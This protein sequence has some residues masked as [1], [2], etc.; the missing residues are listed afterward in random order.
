MKD[1]TL[2]LFLDQ[3]GEP[4][5]LHD[6]E[7]M[8]VDQ[9]RKVLKNWELFLKSGM[10]KEHFT[11]ALYHHLINHCSF[12]AHYDRAGFY[13]T[14]F[15]SGDMA[16]HFLSQFDTRGGRIPRS[17]EYGETYWIA[18]GNDVCQSYYDINIEM[19]RI[20]WKYIPILEQQSKNDQRRAD[21]EMAERLLKKHGLALPGVSQ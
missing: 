15:E 12:I 6:A 5:G 4:G 3:A 21:L 10:K 19:C 13:G 11:E 9:K 17:I 1:N 8:P 20:A 18:G 2:N 7:F 16:R 14:Y